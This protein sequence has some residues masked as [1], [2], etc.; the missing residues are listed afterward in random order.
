MLRWLVEDPRLYH[1]LSHY[2]LMTSGFRI[3]Y[4]SF[5]L[6]ASWLVF[7]KNGTMNGVH[8]FD[9]EDNEFFVGTE[10]AINGVIV[11]MD[12][13]M[14]IQSVP[15]QFVRNITLFGDR[16]VSVETKGG[17]EWDAPTER[18]K[19]KVTAHRGHYQRNHPDNL[20]KV[21]DVYDREGAG[22]VNEDWII[23]EEQTR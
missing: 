3:K 2:K 21:A 8:G 10:Y 5:L 20:L 6:G 4:H 22:P 23:F 7:S 16:R 15:R 17:I 14:F 9:D 18:M 19:L 12:Q 13:T 11:P 1:L